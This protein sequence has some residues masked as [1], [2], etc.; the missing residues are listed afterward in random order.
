MNQISCLNVHIVYL[1]EECRV[2]CIRTSGPLY[3]GLSQQEGW[4][5]IC[6]FR[7]WAHV[8]NKHE[9]LPQRQRLVWWWWTSTSACF[10][11]L[12]VYMW[13]RIIWIFYYI[14]FMRCFYKT[15]QFGEIWNNRLYVQV[16]L[17]Y[18]SFQSF[19]FWKMTDMTL[20]IWSDTSN[21]PVILYIYT[22]M[23]CILYVNILKTFL[24]GF[25]SACIS[26]TYIML[27][28]FLVSQP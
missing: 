19:L 18:V 27:L 15:G 26:F 2:L 21:C 6:R 22:N 17:R 9:K 7:Q 16:I 23:Y 20:W 5:D 14:V 12:Y 10:R 28:F 11:C 4:V 8:L 3:S 24:D 13:C 1:R 25:I